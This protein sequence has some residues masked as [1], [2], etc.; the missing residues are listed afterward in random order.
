MESGERFPSQVAAAPLHGRIPRDVC[1]WHALRHTDGHGECL[2]I[3][4]NRKLL[5]RGQNDAIDPGCV[6]TQKK[7]KGDDIFQ[8]DF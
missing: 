6:K 1:V 4:A 8:F 5:Q 2:L 7:A 3:G